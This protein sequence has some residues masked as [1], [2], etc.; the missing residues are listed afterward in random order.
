MDLNIDVKKRK[1]AENGLEG[2]K[3]RWGRQ[4]DKSF[5]IRGVE[6]ACLWGVHTC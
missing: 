2:G 3:V 6:K 1:N 4:E 5:A